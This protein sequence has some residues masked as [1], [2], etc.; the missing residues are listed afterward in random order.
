MFL[1]GFWCLGWVLV[2]FFGT[3]FYA[4]LDGVWWVW[5]FFGGFLDLVFFVSA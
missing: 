1:D 4:F 5:V 2:G 3:D